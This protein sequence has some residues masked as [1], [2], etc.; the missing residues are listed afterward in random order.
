MAPRSPRRSL[1]SSRQHTAGA[2][3]TTQLPV[4]SALAQI[5]TASSATTTPVSTTGYALCRGQ[6]QCISRVC[7]FV[8]CLQAHGLHCDRS[9]AVADDAYQA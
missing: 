2:H 3:L 4:I 9:L 7:L 8:S 6:P 5:W 1:P